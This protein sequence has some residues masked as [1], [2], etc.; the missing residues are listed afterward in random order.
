MIIEYVV[1]NHLKVVYVCNDGGVCDALGDLVPVQ[2]CF[3]SYECISIDDIDSC[4]TQ[5]FEVEGGM[6]IRF[7]LVKVGG[8]Y[9][10]VSFQ[11]SG[12]RQDLDASELVSIAEK[13]IS[14]VCGSGKG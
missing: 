14:R 11:A 10:I 8:N 6:R 9:S 5:W 7:T 2:S 12:V 4:L 1:R 13:L 3:Q